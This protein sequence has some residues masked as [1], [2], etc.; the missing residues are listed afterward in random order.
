MPDTFSRDSLVIRVE[1]SIQGE[2]VCE[3][4]EKIK[5]ARGLP[6]RIKVDNGP[7]FG[8]RV[9]DAWACF[10]KVRLDYF[11]PG[12]PADNPHIESEH[13]FFLI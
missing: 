3:K 4:P 2:Q 12:T 8:F 1:K 6:R 13:R 7:E 9:L 10:N 5:A 11:R